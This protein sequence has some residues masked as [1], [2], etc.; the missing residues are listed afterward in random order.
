MD[1]DAERLKIAMAAHNDPP[2]ANLSFEIGSS[3]S[4]RGEGEQIYDAA[5]SCHVL[6]WISNKEEF[7]KKL[8]SS[9]KHGGRIRLKNV[10][11]FAD[12][13]INVLTFFGLE[14]QLHNMSNIWHF[15]DI[16]RVAESPIKK[17]G[18]LVGKKKF[19]P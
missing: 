10:H 1:P 7:F 17:S 15:D 6:H 9:L 19:Q 4:F 3:F 5:F 2:R 11:R 8:Y 14:H 16:E 12:L 13:W 18:V